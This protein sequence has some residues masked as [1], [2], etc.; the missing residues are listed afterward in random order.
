[1][2]LYSNV[3]HLLKWC[4]NIR[5]DFLSQSYGFSNSNEAIVLFFTLLEMKA[6]RRIMN[7][8]VWILVLN[9]FSCWTLVDAQ[10]RK[11]LK[12][13]LCILTTR[14]R[15]WTQYAAAAAAQVTIGYS[16]QAIRKTDISMESQ[17]SIKNSTALWP[18]D[19]WPNRHRKSLIWGAADYQ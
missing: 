6:D 16:G 1:M 18:V 9:F 12:S 4:A 15:T 3:K 8:V 14:I 7:L 19:I 2:K 11:L 17:S 5:R 10:V 13:Y